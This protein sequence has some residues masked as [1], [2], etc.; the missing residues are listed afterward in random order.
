MPRMQK[1]HFFIAC[2]FMFLIYFFNVLVTDFGIYEKFP[3]LDVP[4]HFLGGASACFFTASIF[5]IIKK[6]LSRRGFYAFI[7]VGYFVLAF[8]WEIYE[9]LS[10]LFF[11]TNYQGGFLDAG[12]DILSGLLGCIAFLAV[13]RWHWIK[14]NWRNKNPA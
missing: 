4:M 3:V 1:L 12:G 8:A 5:L 9:L 13:T 2:F 14:L 6:Q 11:K 7:F 10:D